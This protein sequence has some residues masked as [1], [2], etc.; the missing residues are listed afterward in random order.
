MNFY[1]AI[2]IPLAVFTPLF[3]LNWNRID[4]IVEES[5]FARFL[6][7]GLLLGILYAFMFVYSISTLKEFIDLTLF[8]V[9]IFLPLLSTGEQLFIVTGKY[10]GRKDIIQ[11]SSSMGGAFSL[12]VAFGVA[13]V[14]SSSL[15]NYVF[16]ALIAAFSF[17]TNVM[18]A[19]LLSIG[20]SKSRILHYYGLAFLI[21]VLFSSSIFLEYWYGSYSLYAIIPEIAVAIM[22]YKRYFHSRLGSN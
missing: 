7:L 13:I 16:V 5:L 9:V 14:S 8:A 15:P 12:P 21:Q 18:S 6:F 22:L 10:R 20:A 3:Y 4:K 17:I 1:P 2:L 11:L 19:A